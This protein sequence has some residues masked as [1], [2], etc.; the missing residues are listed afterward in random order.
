MSG[1]RKRSCAYRNSNP[2]QSRP[3]PTFSS[4]FGFLT[5]NSEVLQWRATTVGVAKAGNCAW[6]RPR[7]AATEYSGSL[8][9][10]FYTTLVLHPNTRY[11]TWRNKQPR[12]YLALKRQNAAICP[13]ALNNTQMYHK[14]HTASPS[15]TAAGCWQLGFIRNTGLH[16]VCVCVYLTYINWRKPTTLCTQFLRSTSRCVYVE[17]NKTNNHCAVTHNSYSVIGYSLTTCFD[18]R[19]SSSGK[20]IRM[21]MYTMPVCNWSLTFASVLLQ[22]DTIFIPQHIPS[23]TDDCTCNKMKQVSETWLWFTQLQTQYLIYIHY[24]NIPGGTATKAWR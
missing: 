14:K 19:G 24:R 21:K 6:W 11:K 13:T 9:H 2:G 16:G 5:G 20:H 17:I 18:P 23:K 1:K 4:T 15:Q 10:L 12:K 8:I 22:G 3:L 7:R